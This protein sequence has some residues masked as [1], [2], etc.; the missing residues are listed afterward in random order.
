MVRP[1]ASSTDDGRRPSA[2]SVAGRR[3]EISVGDL[4]PLDVGAAEIALHEAGRDSA[5][6]ATT[7]GWSRPSWWRMFATVSGVALRPAI[8]RTG[9]AGS[10]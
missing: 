8:W 2:A 7:K 5:S 3:D 9:S 6:T 4:G 1:I 10:R